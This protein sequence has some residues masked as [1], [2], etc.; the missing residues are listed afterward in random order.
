MNIAIITCKKSADKNC[1]GSCLKAYADGTH[2]GEFP[3]YFFHCGGCDSA[4]ES[5]G[6]LAGK[7]SRLKQDEI[8]KVHF[9]SCIKADCP[10]LNKLCKVFKESGIEIELA[11]L[12]VK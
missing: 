9:S 6:N 2:P 10:N 12:T 4:P 1:S 5:N 8:S 11:H 3:A 7:I